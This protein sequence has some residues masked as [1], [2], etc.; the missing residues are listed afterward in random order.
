M[1]IALSFGLVGKPLPIKPPCLFFCSKYLISLIE[2]GDNEELR[3]IYENIL[4]E[5]GMFFAKDYAKVRRGGARKGMRD[6]QRYRQ[7]E[8]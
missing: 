6:I 5:V 3:V 7:E 4:L 2:E 1:S 8:G